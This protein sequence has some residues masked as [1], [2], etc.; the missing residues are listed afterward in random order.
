MAALG[1]LACGLA[2]CGGAAWHQARRARGWRPPRLLDRAECANERAR[3]L[4]A[5]QRE[6]LYGALRL[7]TPERVGRNSQLSHTVAFDPDFLLRHSGTSMHTECLSRKLANARGE[8][9]AQHCGMMLHPS[10]CAGH[11]SRPHPTSRRFHPSMAAT[12]RTLQG[13][14]VLCSEAGLIRQR[15]RVEAMW[16]QQLCTAACPRCRALPGA[17]RG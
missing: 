6:V 4:Q 16:W 3:H 13:L 5:A 12:Q 1:N 10:T 9:R 7:G 11:R 2:D 8:G 17:C 14:R 15:V